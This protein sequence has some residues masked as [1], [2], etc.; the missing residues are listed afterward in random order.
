LGLA[1][2]SCVWPTWPRSIPLKRLEICGRV[3]L[4]I[5]SLALYPVT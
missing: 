4:A 1:W 5:T 3:G 2:M